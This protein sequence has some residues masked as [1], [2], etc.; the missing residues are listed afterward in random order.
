MYLKALFTYIIVRRQGVWPECSVQTVHGATG[1][2]R[3]SDTHAVKKYHTEKM[4]LIDRLVITEHAILL[5]SWLEEIQCVEY[6]VIFYCSP[7]F[8]DIACTV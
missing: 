3:D 2:L 6:V 7:I 4:K 8:L 5:S 1:S